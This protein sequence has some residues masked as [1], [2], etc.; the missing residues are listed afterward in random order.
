MIGVVSKT[1]E[2][3]VITEFF[4][5]FKTPWE[6]YD[7]AHK[8]DVIIAAGTAPPET[9]ATLIL[10]Y[11]SEK[12]PCDDCGILKPNSSDTNTLAL[13]GNIKFPIYGKSIA[14]K[15]HYGGNL[16]SNNSGQVLGYEKKNGHQR[17]LRFGYDLFEEVYF[18]LTK[19]QPPEYALFPTL[20]YQI[21]IL[22]SL[23]TESGIRLLEIP[24]SPAGY[25]FI[26]CMTHDID[27]IRIRD[28]K[29]DHT[30]W[31]FL[32]RA[33]VGTLIDVL[34]SKRNWKDLYLNWKAVAT[35]P[36]V[37][38]GLSPDFWFKFERYA[39]LEKNVNA[40]STFFFIP[41]KNRVGNKVGGANAK[42]RASKYDVL[43][44][45]E[46]VRNLLN[47][48]FDVGVHGID[49]WHD[50]LS[51]CEEKKRITDVSKKTDVGIR[52][53]WLYFNENTFRMLDEAGFSYDSTFG[54]N[55][56][57]GFRAGTLQ[58]FKPISVK[59]I[60][61]LP[62]HIQ[63]TALFNPK[64]MSLT[65]AD[66]WQL[67][68]YLIKKAASHGGA[69][70]VLWHDRSLSPERL[71]EDFYIKLLHEIKSQQAWFA[72]A[73]DAVDWF[74]MRRSAEFLPNGDVKFSYQ[75]EKGSN[76]PKL[77]LRTYNT[78]SPA[79][80]NDSAT[81]APFTDTSI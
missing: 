75:P 54:Y 74:R 63:D 5:L 1:H 2:T 49:A 3:E 68:E 34:R 6:F 48:G 65:K 61:E 17:I 13:W 9:D 62:L 52:M 40:R 38:L 47:S 19:G 80:D 23:I 71:Y 44:I 42:R 4:E 8:Y 69:L 15:N 18:L 72:T 37:H 32:Y 22:R 25:K 30:M 7:P 76:L 14:F 66:A 59:Q 55:D 26:A 51:A 73:Q 56:T 16:L 45:Q 31:G 41:F 81:P 21:D 43:D 10:I 11:S 77:I 53:H 24:P 57:V 64:H 70:T 79:A 36:L 67:C 46:V 20:D 28:H 60:H 35:L 78:A 12:L 33:T 27:F 58:A 39:E 29:F 50:I